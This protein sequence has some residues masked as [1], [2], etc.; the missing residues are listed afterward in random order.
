APQSG[1]LTEGPSV[2]HIELNVR[3]RLSSAPPSAAPS[4]ALFRRR[5]DQIDRKEARSEDYDKTGY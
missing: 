3:V 5:K 2:I 1:L 4:A